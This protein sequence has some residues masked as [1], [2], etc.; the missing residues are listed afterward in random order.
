MDIGYDLNAV[1]RLLVVERLLHPCSKRSAV[2]S[3][4]GYFFRYDFTE[5]DVYRA[6]DLLASARD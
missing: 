4:D 5:D 3:R 6:L 1:M 2:A